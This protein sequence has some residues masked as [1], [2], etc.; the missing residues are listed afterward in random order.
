[1]L[2]NIS[3][4]WPSESITSTSAPQPKKNK[5]LTLRVSSLETVLSILEMTNCKKVRW[6]MP[7]IETSLTLKLCNTGLI[8]VKLMKNQQD[9][10]FSIKDIL[11]ISKK[12]TLTVK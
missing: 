2:A 12:S 3:Q 10:N 11:K 4:I 8:L 5:K 9:A 1:M 7:L 6:N